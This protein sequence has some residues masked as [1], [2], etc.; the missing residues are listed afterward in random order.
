MAHSPPASKS[1]LISGT[2]LAQ[3]LRVLAASSLLRVGKI[4]SHYLGTFSG[5]LTWAMVRFPRSA[6]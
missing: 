1:L 6:Y 4:M 3:N 2:S 5:A